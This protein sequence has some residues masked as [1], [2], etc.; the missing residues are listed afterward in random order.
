M[1]KDPSS[2][3]GGLSKGCIRDEYV[4]DPETVRDGVLLMLLGAG[5]SVLTVYLLSLVR[6]LV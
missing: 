4:K 1:S 3:F 2:F 6:I 5:S